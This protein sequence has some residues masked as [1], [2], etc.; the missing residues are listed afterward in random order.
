MRRLCIILMAISMLSFIGAIISYENKP[1]EYELIM[2]FDDFRAQDMIVPIPRDFVR[3]TP[4]PMPE[5]VRAHI[6]EMDEL[7][8]EI[9]IELREMHLESLGNYF[10]TGYCA[11]SKCCGSYANG[12]CADGTYAKRADEDHK[13]TE[14]STCAIDRKI[15]GFNELIYVPSENRIYETHDTGSGVKG[16]HIDCFQSSHDAVRSFNTRTEEIFAVSFEYHLEQAS[17]Y[18]VHKVIN[19]E[20]LNIEEKTNAI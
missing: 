12:I 10:I 9:P 7:M 15:H 4:V 5:M 16:K 14:W 20:F 11:C 3:P 1:E 2:I 13:L 19:R 18:D 17:K 8:S 6:D